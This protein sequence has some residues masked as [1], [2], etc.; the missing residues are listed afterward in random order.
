MKNNLISAIA[1]WKSAALLALV[2]MVAA[3]AFSG[4]LSTTQTAE[5]AI[6]MR[7]SDG[8]YSARANGNVNNGDVVYIQNGAT[9]FV[10]YEITAIGNAEASFTH[11]SAQSSGQVLYCS[12]ATTAGACDVDTTDGGSTV[13]V[14]VAADSGGGGIIVKQTVLAT[15]ITTADELNVTVKPVPTKLT[16]TATPKAVNAGEGAATAT[17]STLTFRLTDQN[18]NPIGGQALTIIASHGALSA[19]S[20]APSAWVDATDGTTFT[21]SGTQVGTVTTSTDGGANAE[22]NGAGHAAVT[23][24]PGGVANTATITARVVGSALT[25]TVD[26]VMYGAA[27]TITAK[28]EQSALQIGGSTFIVVTVTDA[29]GNAVASHNVDVKSGANGVVGPSTPSN[30]V[31]VSNTVD[32]DVAPIGG[33]AAGAGDLPACGDAPDR[34][35][36]TTTAGVDE[37]TWW[38]GNGTNADG[39]CVIQVTT[40]GGDTA[41]PADD[42]TRSKHTITIQGPAADGS[43]DVTVDIEIGGAPARI[44]SDARSSMEP[45]EEVTINVTVVDDEDV[46]VGEVTIE[47]I[48]T[49]GGGLITTPIAAMTS[50]GRAKFSYLAPSRAGTVD[51]LVR[52]KNTLGVETARLPITITI[53][54]AAEEAPDAPPATWNNELVSGQNV[55]VWNGDD[56]ADPS[57]ASADGVTAIWSYDTGSG[58]WDGYFPDAADVPGG[59]TLTSLSSNQAYVVIV[60]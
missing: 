15:G 5:A 45:G 29:G 40:A 16:A 30:E 22:V 55:V 12:P 9:G 56:G 60:N 13:A 23:F 35:D 20:D 44:T 2:A 21:G 34:T 42:T 1:G 25:Q 37:S 10:L 18:G 46:R 51:L 50:D 39:K 59:N 49:D 14:K 19:A 41:S 31:G 36:D 38:T 57:E 26:V 6:Q 11:T 53:G 3:V 4:V 33:A 47:A 32:K 27:K 7:D 58:S 48:K 54:A 8:T 17:T 52:T 28:P 43:A 24:T